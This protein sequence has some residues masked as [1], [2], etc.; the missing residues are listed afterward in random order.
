MCL[1]PVWQNG[2]EEEAWSLK[3]DRHGVDIRVSSNLQWPCIAD[4]VWTSGWALQSYSEHSVSWNT[5]TCTLKGRMAILLAASVCCPHCLAEWHRTA[6]LNLPSAHAPFHL[7]KGLS[8]SSLTELLQIQ[9][10]GVH[11][12]GQEW[13]QVHTGTQALLVSFLQLPQS[14]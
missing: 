8:H 13:H 11:E 4:H 6:A 12:A 10:G 3:S 7:S 1:P 2:L 5:Q 9:W 14:L